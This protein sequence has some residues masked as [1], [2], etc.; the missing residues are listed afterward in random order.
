MPGSN[1]K[2][3]ISCVILAGGESRRFHGN[4]KGLLDYK[5]KKL[6]EHV[7]LRVSPQCSE[8]FISCN[9]NLDHYA[10]FGL[11][12]LQDDLDI[13]SDDTNLAKEVKYQ[14]PLL[15]IATAMSAVT[16]ALLLVCSCDCPQL[17]PNL[18][19]EL[20]RNL[21]KNEAAVSYAYDGDRHQYLASLWR[22]ANCQEALNEYLLAG[23]RAVKEFLQTQH[24]AI[25]DFHNQRQAFV[26][27]NQP[28]DLEH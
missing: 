28:D 10:Q 20:Y 9:R 13:I 17:P 3:N 2:P 23:G 27:I 21:L 12:L 8:T 16:H 26:N 5:G 25:T 7:I 22:V 4:D 24:I 6:I 14:G 19:T 11:P 18:A 15:G 1:N